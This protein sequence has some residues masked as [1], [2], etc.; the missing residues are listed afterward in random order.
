MENLSSCNQETPTLRDV[1][2]RLLDILVEIDKVC[3]KH[4]IQYWIDY[5]T[6]LGA[7]RHK[8]FI[9]W[10]DDIDI[11]V[12]AKDYDSIRKALIAELPEQYAL[13]DT[14]TDKY[15]FIRPGRVRDRHSYAAYPHFAKLKEQGLWV[16]IFQADRA[17][18]KSAKQFVDFFY[19][20]TFREI[21]HYGDVAYKSSLK[22]WVYRLLAYLLHPFTAFAMHASTWIASCGKKGLLSHYAFNYSPMWALEKNIFPLTEVEFE[23][24]RFF[25]PGNYDAHL[26]MRY[27]DYMQLPPEEKR[28][29]HLN[30][31]NIKIW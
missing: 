31:S 16:D 7:V 10:D 8:G 1:Q 14:T 19:R 18:T 11:C 15:V 5:G 29:V 28:R 20:R 3:R 25:A 4:N 23:G 27:G 30:L 9:P 24:H 13:Q 26:R 17:I 12:M 6:L 22:R 2:L 21:H